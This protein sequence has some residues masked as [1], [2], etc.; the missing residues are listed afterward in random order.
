MPG[1]EGLEGVDVGAQRQVGGGVV[2]EDG[3]GG[4]VLV[5]DGGPVVLGGSE[6]LEGLAVG[7]GGGG[8]EEGGELALR[9]GCVEL[10]A[11][12]EEGLCADRVFGL[13]LRGW[14]D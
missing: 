6:A 2:F 13:L 9:G 3:E 5:D 4:V 1:R 11:V 12:G 14:V 7:G 10:D 8:G